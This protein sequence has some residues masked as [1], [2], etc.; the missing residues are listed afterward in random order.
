MTQKP[1]ECDVLIV[2]GGPVGG[3]LAGLLTTLPLRVV[4]VDLL[5]PEKVWDKTRDG[6]TTAIS[7]GSSGIMEKAGIWPQLLPFTTAI[8]EIRVSQSLASGFLHFTQEDAEGHPMGFILDNWR[9]RQ[10]LYTMMEE[11]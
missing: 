10:A 5:A 6:R 1:F 4:V 2:G 8:E 3:V 7:W 11:R 9:L